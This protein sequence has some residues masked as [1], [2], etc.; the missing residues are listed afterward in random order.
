LIQFIADLQN[1]KSVFLI[2]IVVQDF[3]HLS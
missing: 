2:V 3:K 1:F